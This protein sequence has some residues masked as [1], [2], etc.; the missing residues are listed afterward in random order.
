MKP[1]SIRSQKIGM[2]AGTLIPFSTHDQNILSVMHYNAEGS[3]EYVVENKEIP[4]KDAFKG[5]VLWLNL[6]GLFDT[7]L[8]KAIGEKFGLHPLLLEDIVSVDQRPKVDEYEE[9]LFVVLKMLSYN[10]DNEEI[11]SEQVSFVLGKDYVLSFQEREG[12]VF[13]SVRDRIRTM[14]GRMVNSGPDY[15]LYALV[16]TIVDN[17]FI[18]LEK[19]GERL[20]DLEEE[21]IDN[22]SES[23]LKKLYWLKQE[24]IFLRKSIWPIRELISRLERDETGLVRPSTRMYIKDVYD[25][26]IQIIDTIESYRDTLAS[27]MDIYL[28]GVNNK[29]SAVMKVLTIISTIFIPL[30]FI[31]GVYGMN[32]EHMPELKWAYGYYLIWGIMGAMGMAMLVFFR[33]KR[34]L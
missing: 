7:E 14:K 28:S 19:L 13:D 15:L 26:T 12:D 9:N 2:P 1:S 25:H 32:F 22:P 24:M 11:V 16:D 30:T 8:I 6:D 20:E 31:V 34:W 21:I 33:R 27:L 4:A 10:E 18:I 3:A 5:K 23:K 17:Y 29:I